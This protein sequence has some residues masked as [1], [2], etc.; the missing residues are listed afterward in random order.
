[1]ATFC[2]RARLPDGCCKLFNVRC[3]EAGKGLQR[4]KSHRGV[5]P[6]PKQKV[7]TSL[8]RLWEFAPCSPPPLNI[9]NS[10]KLIQELR[11]GP[12]WHDKAGNVTQPFRIQRFGGRH[13]LFLHCKWTKQMGWSA[14]IGS[15]DAPIAFCPIC[16]PR[17]TLHWH[18]VLMGNPSASSFSR[19]SQSASRPRQ[20]TII[21]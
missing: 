21:V 6:S 8:S 19:V 11:R 18:A 9:R 14:P 13:V 7:S 4:T 10:H 1:M 3:L 16:G 2:L 20:A 15:P 17:S 12:T 5:L